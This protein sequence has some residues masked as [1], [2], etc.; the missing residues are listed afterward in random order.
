MH[1]N[2]LSYH[3]MQLRCDRV[4]AEILRPDSHGTKGQPIYAATLK[5]E[6]DGITLHIS[7]HA[8]VTYV[9]LL[10][11]APASS[12]VAIGMAFVRFEDGAQQALEH[13]IEYHMMP[14]GWL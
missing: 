13:F 6:I 5:L 7:A 1:S 3:G 14:A 11:D 12:E 8:R 4:T 2:D 9:A 10:P